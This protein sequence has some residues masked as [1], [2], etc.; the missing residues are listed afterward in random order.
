M[1]K[2]ANA[3]RVRESRETRSGFHLMKRFVMG[4]RILSARDLCESSTMD[5]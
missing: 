1:K 3:A 2:P 4:M 5:G